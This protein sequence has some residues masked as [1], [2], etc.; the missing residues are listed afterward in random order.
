MSTPTAPTCWFEEHS[1]GRVMHVPDVQALPES[2]LRA[3]LEPQGIQSLM[4]LPLMH[5][6]RCLGFVGLDSV[7]STHNY[8]KEE[9]TLLQ[10]FAQMLV[11]IRLRVEAAEEIQALTEG[12]E[13]KVTERTAQLETSVQQLQAVNRELESF[14][15]SASHDLRTPLRGIEGFSTLLLEDHAAQLDDQ[16]REYL[17]RIQRA[18]LH[19]SRLV[20]DLLAYSRLQQLT[21]LVKSVDLNTTLQTV[22]APFRDEIEAREGRLEL[23][24]P[25]GLAVRASPQGLAIVLRNLIDNALKFTPAGEAPR[26]RVEAQAQGDRVLLSVSDQ[27][28][29]FDMKYHDRIF[30]MFQRLHRQEQ[31]P[32]TGIGLA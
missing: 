7:R 31:I 9:T 27:G 6:D 29:G 24:I 13:A 25:D 8:G 1:H 20:N 14:T 19:M 3:F 17:R 15:Y 16:G 32:G 5:G 28:I 21:D 4:A 22:A 30:G 11:N 12:L 2:N 10:L 18:T 26:I 23:A